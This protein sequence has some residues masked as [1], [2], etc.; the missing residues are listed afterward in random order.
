VAQGLPGSQPR[1]AKADRSESIK[2]LSV[3]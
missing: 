2:E 1:T 3:P